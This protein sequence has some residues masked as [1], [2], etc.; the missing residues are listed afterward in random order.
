M[1]LVTFIRTTLR[2]LACKSSMIEDL[3][4]PGNSHLLFEKKYP[5]QTQFL[6]YANLS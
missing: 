1:I 6:S 4:K 5:M 3:L 2:T